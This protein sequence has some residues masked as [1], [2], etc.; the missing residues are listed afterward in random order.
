MNPTQKIFAGLVT[1]VVALVILEFARRRKL[2]E[3]YAWLWMLT[4]IG[5]A[6]LTTWYSLLEWLTHLIGAVTVTTTLFI[7]GLT[8]LLLICVQFSLVI[9]RLTL[10]VR[11][12][13]QE[14]AILTATK[15][16]GDG[17]APQ[18]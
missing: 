16:S 12:L 9:S 10:Q 6:V 3:E 14:L 4:A 15:G 8:F 1:T 13:T 2:K 11:R 5:M 17:P 7:F 18:G